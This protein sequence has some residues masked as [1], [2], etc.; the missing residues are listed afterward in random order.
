MAMRF[1]AVGVCLI[2][3]SVVSCGNTAAPS[4][5][6]TGGGGTASGGQAGMAGTAGVAGSMQ[7]M[8]PTLGG[9]CVDDP[10]CDDGLD[11]TDDACDAGLGRCRFTP[12]NE[13]CQDELYCN[14]TEVCQPKMGCRAGEPVS[15]TDNSSCT[16][17]VC[18]EETRSCEHRARDA[19]GDG[20]PVW[21]CG[22]ND[23]DDSDPKVNGN[24]PEICGNGVDDNCNLRIDEAGCVSP[25]YD[26]CA[27]ALSVESDG[28]Y[29]LSFVAAGEDF[30]LSCAE[31]GGTRRDVVVALVVPP[32]PAR[33]VDVSVTSLDKG[34]ALSVAGSCSKS[35]SELSCAAG[36]SLPDPSD[37]K[38]A[39]LHLYSLTKGAY[40]LYVSGIADDTASLNVAYS[41]ASAPPTN[42]TCGDAGE[43]EPGSSVRVSLASATLD[44]TSACGKPF[45]D[46]VYRFELAEPQDVVLTAFPLDAYGVPL[47]SLRSERCVPA[48]S[49]LDCRLSAPSRLWQ[50]GLPAGTYYV[51]VGSTG[52]GDVDLS[53]E[54]GPATT[55]PPDEGCQAPPA[56]A[57]GV[58]EDIDLGT[59]TN[60]VA[61]QCL[62]GAA[63]ATYSLR[64][65]EVSDLLVVERL[66]QGDTGA[67]RVSDAACRADTDLVC[68]SAPALAI[69]KCS[70][71]NGSVCSE[72]SSVRGHAQGVAAGEYAVT[73]ESAVGSP[74]QLTVFSRPAVPA[75]LVAIAD[76]CNDAVL[77]P[78]TGGRFTGNTNN[79]NAD[80]SASCDFGVGAPAGAPEQMLRL[81]LSRPRRVL[82]DAAGSDFATLIALRKATDC[83]GPEVVGGCAPGCSATRSFLD[84]VLAAGDYYVQVDGYVGAAGHWQLD[85]F[86]ADPGGA[87][88]P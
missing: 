70:P 72:T 22:G 33:D 31:P 73:A 52:P 86:T 63:D 48:S 24:A 2:A 34:L 38:V 67:V 13:R 60:R 64:L 58:T 32:G 57:V 3:A 87:T 69:C 76:G 66:S 26:T 47:L 4:S 53:L 27:D 83:P 35:A 59:H 41:D 71:W 18:V 68:E 44:T 7:V 30:S 28:V 20:D 81:H 50:R 11:C 80:F 79:A 77:I 51:V 25:Q 5:F 85:V 14:G 36:V 75:T 42:E 55:P 37:G 78:E 19:D 84:L 54:L 61:S 74:V 12:R 49:E 88:A 39:R 21:N 56:L 43:L 29:D 23:C 65:A 6:A 15:C 82:L 40:P 1:R 45:G 46:L 16:I 9:P 62:P 10:Q 17:D 8:D